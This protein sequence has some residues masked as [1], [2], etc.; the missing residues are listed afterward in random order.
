MGSL[1]KIAIDAGTLEALEFPEVTVDGAPDV[2]FVAAGRGLVPENV[3]EAQPE[4]TGFEGAGWV[5]VVEEGVEEF[6]NR[7][8]V[9]EGEDGAFGVKAMFEGIE[10]NGDLAFGGLGAG[11]EFSVAT[12][13]GDLFSGGHTGCSLKG[14]AREDRVFRIG[15]GIR[16]AGGRFCEVVDGEGDSASARRGLGGRPLD[17]RGGCCQ[18][19]AKRRSSLGG[20]SVMMQI[21]SF[22]VFQTSKLIAVLYLMVFAVI[23][24]PVGLIAITVSPTRWGG[25]GLVLVL[26]IPVIYGVLGF[27]FTAIACALYNVVAKWVGGIA[28]DIGPAAPDQQPQ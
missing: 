26:L 22:G 6:V 3:G 1:G 27:V 5:E 19:Q 25:L 11:A 7:L 20:I 10:A 12:V 15:G 16:A 4:E 21:K 18:Y 14:I 28:I 13:G 9:W 8:I 24:I 17:R 23:G 2:G